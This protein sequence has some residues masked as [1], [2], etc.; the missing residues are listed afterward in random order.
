MTWK[1]LG[2]NFDTGVGKVSEKVNRRLS[3]RN[4]LRAG[5]VSTVAGIA[6]VALGQSPASA[7]K[8]SPGCGPTKSCKGCHLPDGCPKGY[9]LCLKKWAC[10]NDYSKKCC[11]CEWPGGI[12]ESGHNLGK[13]G[14]GFT[15][16]F[17]CVKKPHD[18]TTCKTWCTCE[19]ECFCCNC[20][21][22]EDV[23]QEMHRLG[24][25]LQQVR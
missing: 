18:A 3:R 7:Y 23:R 2:E 4:A 11:Y 10:K 1:G 6:A 22:A 5:V 8:Y 25:H 12:W 19:S 16:C 14:H 9:E 13:G 24:L 15:L 21:S 17:D 20:V